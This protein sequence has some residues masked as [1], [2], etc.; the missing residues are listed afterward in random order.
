MV[1]PEK[2]DFYRM[3]AYRKMGEDRMAEQLANEV[4]RART[5][6]DGVERA[7]IRIAEARV[8]LEVVAAR[9][10]DLDSALLFGKQALR[11]DRHSLPS[12]SMVS[13][14]LGQVL[15]AEY[16][17]VRDSPTQ[18]SGWSMIV[19]AR[20][21]AE[22]SAC[23]ANRALSLRCSSGRSGRLRFPRPG[24]PES[25]DRVA[26]S[27]IDN[28]KSPQDLEQVHGG[29]R[30]GRRSHPVDQPSEREG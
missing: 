21:P 26:P 11:G 22:D 20:L 29:S 27:L 28:S 30:G 16:P 3:D 6:F 2:F 24:M 14:D 5:D 10:G 8:T 18:T 25:G 9:Q 15:Q 12:L 19:T 23:L 4:I 17:H 13:S 7:P 1:D